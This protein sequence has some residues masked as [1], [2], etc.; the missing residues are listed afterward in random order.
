M[1]ENRDIEKVTRTILKDFRLEAGEHTWSR[2]D[3]ELDKKQAALYKQRAT[4]Y[5]LLSAC[6]ALFLCSFITCHYIS[7]STLDAPSSVAA[8]EKTNI[9][10]N[11]TE[12]SANKNDIVKS[13][14]A[15]ENIPIAKDKGNEDAI[16]NQVSGTNN[17]N[18][19]ELLLSA[20]EQSLAENL[21]HNPVPTGVMSVT[22][23]VDK[24]VTK[25]ELIQ[26]ESIIHPLNNNEW[27]SRQND[28]ALETETNQLVFAVVDKD[29]L[30]SANATTAVVPSM[31]AE[32]DS[33]PA[34][35]GK[36]VSR[37]SIAAFYA[38]SLS[39]QNLKDNTADG[40]DDAAMYNN[41]EKE[42]YSFFSGF[43]LDYKIS[44][45][46]S[47]ASGIH[48]SITN[49]AITLPVMHTGYNESKEMHYLY[50]TSS[51]VIQMPLEKNQPL[52]EEDSLEMT[53]VCNQSLKYLEV[54]LLLRFQTTKNKF[55]FYANTGLS[56]N[57]LLQEKATMRIND[58]EVTII[59]NI[60][61]LKQINYSLLV[62]AGIEYKVYRDAGIFLE[63]VFKTAITSI[64]HDMAVNSYPYTIG[65]KIGATLRF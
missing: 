24:P 64:N 46:W 9:H 41:R 31:S 12:T 40:F 36:K 60:D 4:R 15:V 45:R 28:S 48:Y 7:R 50:P 5:K 65:L 32:S 2:L 6:L 11:A 22:T 61:G 37:L 30:D 44:T 55:T 10:G 21:K 62:G 14:R 13:T 20:N 1:E 25:N 19:R 34:V 39:F 17:P 42:Q 51:G 26:S 58:E 3:A 57:F 56:V 52:N 63:P 59:N 38:P 43:L 35:W 29:S 54:P 49:Y 33:T 53:S 18:N 23:E 16:A 47:V 27:G 8:I